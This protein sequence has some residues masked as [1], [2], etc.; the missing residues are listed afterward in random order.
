M[1]RC[2][3]IA[4][5]IIW[6]GVQWLRTSLY[7]QACNDCARHYMIRCAVIALVIIWSG[8]QWLRTSLYDQVCSDCPRHYMIRCAVIAHVIIWSGVQW[9]CTSLYDQVCSD[10]A[11]HYM[12]RC[13]VIAHMIIVPRS[14]VKSKLALAHTMKACG[15]NK[16]AALFTLALSTRCRW[17]VSFTF[18]PPYPRYLQSRR[19]VIPTA[20]PKVSG[21][22]RNPV[23]RSSSPECC[24]YAGSLWRINFVQ[25]KIHRQEWGEQKQKLA[26]ASLFVRSDNIM[27]V[28]GSAHCRNL[29]KNPVHTQKSIKVSAIFSKINLSFRLSP[30]PLLVYYGTYSFQF[31][32]QSFICQDTG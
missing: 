2:A 19:R 31:I 30:S 21:G 6:S 16:G 27:R 29:K 17:A 11:R 7:D 26:C 28:H 32:G 4:Y 13:A 18:L 20:R 9:L 10:C 8:V 1:T 25:N 23:R 3:V 14:H 12:T 5:V 15:R 22:Y 24:H